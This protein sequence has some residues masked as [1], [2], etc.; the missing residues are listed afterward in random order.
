VG[1]IC[2]EATSTAG[3]GKLPQFE[4]ATIKPFGSSGL[5]GIQDFPGGGIAAGHMNLAYS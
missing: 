2:V 3:H 1:S 4:V 5:A